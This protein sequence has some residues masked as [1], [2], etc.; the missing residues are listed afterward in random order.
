MDKK[1][2][3][4]GSD[5]LRDVVGFDRGILTTFLTLLKSPAQVVDDYKSRTGKFT[6]PFS[7][8]LFAISSFYLASGFLINW[9]SVSVFILGLSDNPNYS[10]I[11][12]F[13]FLLLRSYLIVLL[14][15]LLILVC[16]ILTPF[17]RNLQLSFYDHLVWS[18]YFAS[19]NFAVFALALP[20]SRLLSL[21]LP[22]QLFS[23]EIWMRELV[24]FM[25]VFLLAR[26]FIRHRLKFSKFNFYTEQIAK[27]LKVRYTIALLIS[28]II[29][30]GIVLV[31]Q[32]VW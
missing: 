21:I 18:L 22:I 26:L 23:T 15:S 3:E 5:F 24:I 28:A 11:L 1:L 14:L 20:V 13:V 17:T 12:N 6:S 9:D 7:L 2:N 32:E 31:I 27:K 29:I 8:I 30:A 10:G 25:L 16:I 4:I 19:I